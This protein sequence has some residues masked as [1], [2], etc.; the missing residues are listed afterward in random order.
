V[1]VDREGGID[2]E[3]VASATRVVSDALD[4]DASLDG[5][6]VLEVSSPGVERP[7]RIPEHFRRAVG[8]TV[9]VKTLP[10]AQGERRHDGILDAADDTGIVVDGQ[11]IAYD[12][13]E[14]ARTTFS[15]GPAPRPGRG[16]KAKTKQRVR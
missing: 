1:S 16:T 13:I 7:L 11:A 15:W 2:L 9:T 4:D 10:G 5:P 8:S 6:Y 3:G 12:H 14:R